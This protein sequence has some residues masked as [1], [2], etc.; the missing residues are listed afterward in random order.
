MAKNKENESMVSDDD[1]FAPEDTLGIDHLVDGR[2]Y[3]HL[4]FLQAIKAPHYSLTQGR[5]MDGLI[6]LQIAADQAMRIATAIGRVDEEE[7]K[8]A[9]EDYEKTLSKIDDDFIK[10]TKVADFQ[11]FYILKKFQ[12][13]SE[14]KGS[15]MI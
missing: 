5:A 8:K 9:T 2:Y 11:L 6:S 4:V 13:T 1:I 12:E 14:K 3:L 15:V 7:L 10:K